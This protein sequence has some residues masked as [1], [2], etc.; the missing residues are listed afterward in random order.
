MQKSTD[1]ISHLQNLRLN[2]KTIIQYQ[3]ISRMEL[4]QNSS[5]IITIALGSVLPSVWIRRK[6]ADY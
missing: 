2:L 6:N 5:A 4:R 3:C 1:R